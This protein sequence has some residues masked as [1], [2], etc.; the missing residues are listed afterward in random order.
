MVDK[1][2]M[3]GAKPLFVKSVEPFLTD[4][5][6]AEMR[7]AHKDKECVVCYDHE[8]FLSE[9]NRGGLFGSSP[10]LLILRNL[11]DDGVQAIAPLLDY[12][13][14]DT[15]AIIEQ[16]TLKKV[17]AYQKLK[18]ECAF[19]K[20]E[21]LPSRSVKKWLREYMVSQGLVLAS[22]IP[23]Y[24]ID[25]CGTQL[26][27]LAHEVKKLK[28][29]ANGGEVTESMVNAVASTNPEANNF[30]LVDSFVHKRTKKMMEE[31]RKVGDTQLISMLHFLLNYLDRLYK[32]ATYRSQKRN[33]EEIS[34]L[35]GIPK[36]IIQTKYFTALSVYPKGKLLKLIDIL[37]DL[38]LQMRLSKWDR[39]LLFEVYLLKAA[40]V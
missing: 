6:I 22:D 3:K 19:M 26:S 32:I 36:F 2:I 7:L 25:R 14:E 9:I 33:A 38:D 4:I 1:S 17:K 23:G 35:I 16:I 34:D 13:T 37:N 39:R 5:F 18:A 10:K 11:T 30:E 15:L 8:T 29:L 24:L 27:V 20:L 21:S 40:A 31:L 12:S 28:L